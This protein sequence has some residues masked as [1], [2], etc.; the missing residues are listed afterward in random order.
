[1]MINEDFFDS[2]I[3][4]TINDETQFEQCNYSLVLTG[5]CYKEFDANLASKTLKMIDGIETNDDIHVVEK[6]QSVKKVVL[7]FNSSMN[8]LKQVKNFLLVLYKIFGFDTHMTITIGKPDT[9]ESFSFNSFKRLAEI[10]NYYQTA[11]ESY[12][13]QDSVLVDDFSYICYIMI[14]KE[15]DKSCVVAYIELPHYSFIKREVKYKLLYNYKNYDLP[16][17]T[18][19]RC[20]KITH[21]ALNDVIE[22]LKGEYHVYVYQK[23]NNIYK[24]DSTELNMVEVKDETLND[25]LKTFVNSEAYFIK[26]FR[27]IDVQGFQYF[28]NKKKFNAAVTVS[29]FNSFKEE[30]P[31][32]IQYGLIIKYDVYHDEWTKVADSGD[33]G[34][35]CYIVKKIINAGK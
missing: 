7:L 31:L 34:D 12:V 2:D 33:V 6:S 16:I 21:K 4:I 32:S 18:D 26:N 19:K 29:L 17:Q 14:G 23:F 13:G 8:M 22:S 10:E 28:Y 3:D 5:M 30:P 1:M 25:I 27:Y 20:I 15:I 35:A 11:I 24:V 9:G